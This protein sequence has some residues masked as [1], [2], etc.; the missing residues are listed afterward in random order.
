M[1]G[2]NA[3]GYWQACIKEYNVLIKKKV[4]VEVKKEPWMH[5]KS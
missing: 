2:A 5:S 4:W 3:E 1:G